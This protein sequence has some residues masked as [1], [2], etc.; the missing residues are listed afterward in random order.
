MCKKMC[1]DFQWCKG[2]QL[3]KGSLTSRCTLLTNV[4]TTLPGWTFFNEGNWAEPDEWQ[5]RNSY[6]GYKGSQGFCY[7]KIPGIDESEG[8]YHNIKKSPRNIFIF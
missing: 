4:K 8:I 5:E 7:A 1:K 2:I 6:R 3:R